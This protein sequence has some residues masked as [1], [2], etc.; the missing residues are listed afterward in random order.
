MNYLPMLKPP[1]GAV[2]WVAFSCPHAPLQD[3]DALAVVAERIAEFQP[4]R[5]ICLGDLHE[6]DSASRWPSEYSWTIEH[7]FEQANERVLKPLRL[8]NRNAKCEYLFLPGNHDDNILSIARID[9]KVRGRCNYR[10][11]QYAEGK[12]GG[13]AIWLNEEMLTHWQM[14]CGYR[15]K[16]DGGTYRIGATVFAH[17]Y[18]AGVSGDMAQSINLGWPYGLFVSGHTHRPT[19]GEAMRSMAT[20]TLPLPFWYLN[21]GFTGTFDVDYMARKRQQ[22]W[23]HGVCYGWS[24]PINSPRF[25]RSWDAYCELIRPFEQVRAAA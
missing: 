20:K 7:E 16:R 15:Y 25:S 21:A 24:L 5:V 17:G 18:E 12:K 1:S 11:P 19:P 4:D 10:I 23:G 22:M 8:A 14:P 13:P 3:E 6:A 9:K 2:K